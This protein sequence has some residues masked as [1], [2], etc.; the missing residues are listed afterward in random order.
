MAKFKFLISDTITIDN[1]FWHLAYKIW[2]SYITMLHTKILLSFN[3]MCT[4]DCAKQ[5]Q[6]LVIFQNNDH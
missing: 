2:N 6:A 3:K 5:R 4:N 1:R